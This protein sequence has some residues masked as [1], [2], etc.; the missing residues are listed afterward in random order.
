MGKRR[1]MEGRKSERRLL[2]CFFGF[3]NGRGIEEEG[4]TAEKRGEDWNKNSAAARSLSVLNRLMILDLDTFLLALSR[5]LE[6]LGLSVTVFDIGSHC[7]E[8]LFD[9][10][11]ILCA[12]LQERDAEPVCELF[13]GVVVD[14]FFGAQITLVS[15]EELVHIF[16]GVS[17]DLLKPLFHIVERYLICNIVDHNNTMCPSVVARSDCSESFLSCCIPNLKFD[18]FAVEFNCSNLEVNTNGTDITLSVCVVSK[19]KK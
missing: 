7:G 12:G 10:G 18:G 16:A 8:G 6:V 13:G 15:D 19:P 1:L 11:S 14:N 3:Y 9:V 5:V 4:G 17:V 2:F